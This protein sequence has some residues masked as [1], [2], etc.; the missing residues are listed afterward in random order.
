MVH[1]PAQNRPVCESRCPRNKRDMHTVVGNGLLTGKLQYTC[2]GTFSLTVE[3]WIANAGQVLNVCKTHRP[4]ENL[5]TVVIQYLHNAH[6]FNAQW[7]AC[8]CPY[9]VTTLRFIS[10][11]NREFRRNLVFTVHIKSVRIFW[12]IPMNYTKPELAAKFLKTSL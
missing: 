6:K 1:I 4:K 5:W 2:K 7:E 9:V 11:T 8:A 10:K 3:S 12:G